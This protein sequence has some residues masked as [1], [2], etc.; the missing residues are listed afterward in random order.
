MR[1]TPPTPPTD[2]LASLPPSV[3]TEL[4]QW[5]LRASL[6]FVGKSVGSS[7]SLPKATK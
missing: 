1:S 2:A 4:R 7:P 6:R 3:L 5:R